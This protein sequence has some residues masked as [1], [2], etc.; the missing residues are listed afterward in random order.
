MQEKCE[1][2]GKKTLDW[3]LGTKSNKN[4]IKNIYDCYSSK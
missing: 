1:C 2:D 4:S 3:I